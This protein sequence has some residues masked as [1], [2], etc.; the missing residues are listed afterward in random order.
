MQ[1]HRRH[2]H[3]VGD[4]IMAAVVGVDDDT[5]ERKRIMKREYARIQGLNLRTHSL[6]LLLSDEGDAA[7]TTVIADDA[8]VDPIRRLDR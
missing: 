8:D 3:S 4:A 5:H 2:E 6:L 1:T 7:T